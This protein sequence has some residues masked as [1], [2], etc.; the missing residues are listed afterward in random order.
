MQKVTFAD[1]IVR[2]LRGVGNYRGVA[3][4]AEFWYFQLFVF[5]IGIVISTFETMAFP[6]SPE[7]SFQDTLLASPVSLLVSLALLPHQIALQVRRFHDA[8]FSGKW[9]LLYLPALFFVAL[10][11]GA[12]LAVESQGQLGT[13]NGMLNIAGYAY[14]T[15][16][17]L[18]G[19]QIFFLIVML[20]P[21]KP[22]NRGNKYAP[23]YDPEQQEQNP[24]DP[25]SWQPRLD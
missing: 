4:R 7:A 3:T 9:V 21:S 25:G 19:V 18:G 17:I 10:T 23:G 12:Y 6:L 22:A 13:I 15:L 14:P 16:M 5:L 8:G 20:Q 24:T 1:A 2:G 11:L